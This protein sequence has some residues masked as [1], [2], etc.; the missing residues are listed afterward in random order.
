MKPK[1]I[2]SALAFLDSVSSDSSESFSLF[3]S[4]T[5]NL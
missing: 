4:Y 2:I 3:G 1:K 5:T